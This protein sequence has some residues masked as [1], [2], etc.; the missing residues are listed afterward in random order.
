MSQKHFGIVA[1]FDTPGK[2]LEAARNV[3]EAGFRVFDVH[4][5][6]PVHGMD[7][8]MGLSGSKVSWIVLAGGLSGGSL[9]M[10]MQWWMS[11]VDYTLLIGG[12]PFFSWQAFVPVAYECT[13]LLAA[14]GAVFGMFALNRLPLLYHPVFRHPSFHRATDDRFF[15]SIEAK[16][17]KFDQE[18]VTALL[19]KLG[20]E[21]ILMVEA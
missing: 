17:P 5:P 6:F 7:G 4:S 21:N 2:L 11:A 12:K 16:D 9:G 13:I 10:L 14:F 18:K 1:E 15:I 19:E 8:A 20:G 3:Y